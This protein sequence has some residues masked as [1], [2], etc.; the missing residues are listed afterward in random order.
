MGRLLRHGIFN[1]ADTTVNISA[2]EAL[3]YLAEFCATRG[4]QPSSTASAASITVMVTNLPLG[5]DLLRELLGLVTRDVFP[6][7]LEDSLSGCIFALAT[8]DLVNLALLP[9]SVCQSVYV[10]LC[11]SIRIFAP[12]SVCLC[13]TIVFCLFTFL[14]HSLS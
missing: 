3:T 8:L 4:S 11:S 1:L 5:K 7:Q 13:F 6:A 14:N 10:Y 12:G 9:V 2:L